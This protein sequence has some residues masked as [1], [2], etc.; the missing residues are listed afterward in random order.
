MV[1]VENPKHN[2]APGLRGALTPLCL[3]KAQKTLRWI[4]TAVT[5][6]S[7]RRAGAAAFVLFPARYPRRLAAAVPADAAGASPYEVPG[8]E[9]LNVTNA[10][11]CAKWSLV[12]REV[13]VK[14]RGV[15][16]TVPIPAGELVIKFEGPVY[17]KATMSAEKDFS[18]AIQVRAAR[19]R[20]AAGKGRF[21]PLPPP[22][23][24][25]SQIALP[26]I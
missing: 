7:A 6:D 5:F 17:T 16:A 22:P 11:L 13:P 14:G 2:G 21:G 24:L 25:P 9:K 1:G 26:P 18:E 20:A 12:E 8:V 4:T 23:R 10:Q 19:A 15:F 3:L